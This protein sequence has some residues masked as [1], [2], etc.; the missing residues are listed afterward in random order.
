MKK[1]FLVFCKKKT[2]YFEV[3]SSNQTALDI[4]T[5]KGI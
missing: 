2:H 1:I 4:E 3:V 5:K